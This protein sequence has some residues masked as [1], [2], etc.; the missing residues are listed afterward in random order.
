M[1]DNG[2]GNDA[3][4][5]GV[6]IV[7]GLGILLFALVVYLFFCYCFK[8]ICEKCGQN[9]G[10]LIWIPFLNFIPLLQAAGMSALLILLFLLP[11]VGFIVSIIMW[12]KICTVRRKSPLLVIGVIL[13]P[14]VFIPYLAF[15]E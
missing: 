12:V 2:S 10:I 6:G 9:P 5:A 1:N 7:F 15:S 11:P 3:V 4:A 8:R 14:I 13:L